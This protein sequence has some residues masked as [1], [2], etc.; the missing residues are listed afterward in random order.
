ME[1]GAEGRADAVL[2]LAEDSLMWREVE[3]EV[4]VLDKRTWTYMKING[5][6]AVLWKEIARGATSTGLVE[7][8][9][10]TY[11]IDEQTASRDVDAFLSMVKTHGLLLGGEE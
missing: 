9:C 8:L 2:G 11:E 6:G 4:I 1:P 10:E 7:C 5:S 3:D